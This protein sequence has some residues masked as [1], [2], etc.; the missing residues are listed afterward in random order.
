MNISKNVQKKT[1]DPLTKVQND[2][3]FTSYLLMKCY[4]EKF[5]NKKKNEKREQN[6]K[7]TKM[8]ETRKSTNNN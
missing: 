4:K 3:A 8:K 6:I 1:T 5:K 7:K 2:K